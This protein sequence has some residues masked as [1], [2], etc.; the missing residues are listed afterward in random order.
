MSEKPDGGPAFPMP[1]EYDG[2]GSPVA[3]GWVGMTLRDYFAAKAMQ[4]EFETACRS[5]MNATALAN[6]A[7]RSGRTI[8]KQIA[9]NAYLIAD[10]MIAEREKP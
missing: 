8:E 7:D 1:S 2:Q 5:V 3:A 9:H 6:E 4:V 10:A